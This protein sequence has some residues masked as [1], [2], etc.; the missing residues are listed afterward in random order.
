MYIGYRNG[1]RLN[2]DVADKEKWTIQ[3]IK[4]RSEKLVNCFLIEF[5][6]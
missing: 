3:I 6:L 4:N 1:L 5:K 2:D